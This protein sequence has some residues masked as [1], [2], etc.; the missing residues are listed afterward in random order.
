MAVVQTSERDILLDAAKN[1]Y[2]LAQDISE[3][4]W[5]N[6]ELA[7]NEHKAA[8]LLAK[9]LEKEKFHV[10]RFSG[11]L[12]TAFVATFGSGRPNVGF[13]CEYDAL[14]KI[15]HGCGHNLIA[16][17][18]IVAGLSLQAVLE[19][20]G[21]TVKGTVT[22]FGTPAEEEGCGKA[23]MIEEG[24]FE[25]IDAAFM[26]HPSSYSDAFLYKYLASQNLLV[27]YHAK[28]SHASD[29]PWGG[30]NALDAVM[31]AYSS[32]SL[33]RQQIKPECRIHGVITKGGTVPNVVPDCAQ[34]FY[35]IRAPRKHEVV[36]VREKMDACFRS[37]A[38][39]TGCTVDITEPCPMYENLLTNNRLGNVFVESVIGL[40]VEFPT[41]PTGGLCGSTDMGN[42]SNVVSSIHPKYRICD[43]KNHTPEFTEASNTVEAHKI[44]QVMGTAM[45]LTG[46]RILQN[47]ELLNEVKT[48]FEQNKPL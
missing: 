46:L 13:I 31:L 41:G 17:A 32:I 7:F 26:V 22:V 21:A 12:S 6:P 9:C 44:T 20:C 14:P 34:L 48:E 28:E 3:T 33:L 38:E 37:A 2:P 43:A 25:G 15:G 45:G 23:L 39:T 36:A 30:K 27:T 18:G 42:V 29:V 8:N 35:Y 10:R 47:K 5:N 16:E 4:I 1:K 40:G 11:R 19:Q 24:L